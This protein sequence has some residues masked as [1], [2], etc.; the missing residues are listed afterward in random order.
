VK[1]PHGRRSKAMKPALR[2]NDPHPI[3]NSLRDSELVAEKI[4]PSKEAVMN[5]LK[6]GTISSIGVERETENTALNSSEASAPRPPRPG[7]NI[8]ALRRLGLL[9]T[10]RKIPHRPNHEER[11][12][13][14]V[15]PTS[16]RRKKTAACYEPVQASAPPQ[17][18]RPTC[19]AIIY[20]PSPSKELEDD[21]RE[22]RQETARSLDW[23]PIEPIF[24]RVVFAFTPGLT[25]SKQSRCQ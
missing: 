11:H 10:R 7:R 4:P 13:N 23:A 22:T 9:P 19:L 1:D 20:A 17:V 14:I 15:R 25:N 21:N 18:P 2:T 16:I 5:F 3:A 6:S 12:R 8:K 24:P